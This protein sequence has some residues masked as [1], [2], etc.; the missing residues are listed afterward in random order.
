M[1]NA[2]LPIDLAHF[3]QHLQQTPPEAYDSISSFCQW[4]LLYTDPTG[5]RPF[6]KDQLTPSGLQSLQ[7]AFPITPQLI[8]VSEHNREAWARHWCQ[9]MKQAIAGETEALS[10]ERMQYVSLVYHA[11]QSK[12]YDAFTQRAEALKKMKDRKAQQDLA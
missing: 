2:L 12:V 7:S 1:A 6:S 11:R 5:K 9:S 10:L 8:I 3:C 4:N